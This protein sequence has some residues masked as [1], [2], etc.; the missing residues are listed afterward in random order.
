MPTAE[1]ALDDPT[2]TGCTTTRVD[3][4]LD[5]KPGTKKFKIKNTIGK[6]VKNVKTCKNIKIINK[7]L[8]LIKKTK[9]VKR[10]QMPASNIS[11]C[12]RHLR[13]KRSSKNRNICLRS[14]ASKTPSRPGQKYRKRLFERNPI[15]YFHGRGG[16]HSTT[17]VA[18]CLEL[19]LK[20][21]SCHHFRKILPNCCVF[22]CKSIVLSYSFVNFGLEPSWSELL[23]SLLKSPF[24]CHS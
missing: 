23:A 5:D 20:F 21:V 8:N 4:E 3:L 14:D 11:P 7:K 6:F 16:S 13:R 2:S 12:I 1:G 22:L 18:R 10:N 17:L 19:S 9:T 15:Q 24:S